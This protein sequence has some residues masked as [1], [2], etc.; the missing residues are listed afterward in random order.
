MILAYSAVGLVLFVLAS[1]LSN[2]IAVLYKFIF[3]K[4]LIPIV[5]MQLMSVSI[6]LRAYGVTESRY[7]VAL[8]GIFSLA[9][10]LILT[11]R[12]KTK[13]GIIAVSYTHLDVYKRQIRF[14]SS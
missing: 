8:F 1:R 9:V 6:R 7:Y 4:V 2:R 3:P 11:L 14:C 5:G 13:N 12:P 10:G